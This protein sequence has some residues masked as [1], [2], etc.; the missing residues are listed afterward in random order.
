MLYRTPIHG[1]RSWGWRRRGNE[2]FNASTTTMDHRGAKETWRPFEGR[3]NR[4]RNSDRSS[5]DTTI[6]L[7][8][9]TSP[10][11]KTKES[12]PSRGF[13]RAEGERKMMRGFVVDLGQT[14]KRP[15]SDREIAAVGEVLSSV[16]LL[17]DRRKRKRL[18]R[19]VR[20]K[21]RAVEIGLKAKGKWHETAACSSELPSVFS[22]S[23]DAVF[24]R[25]G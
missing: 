8:A 24:R 1:Q 20:E 22:V 16:G 2:P 6:H 25:L 23:D 9:V 15:L 5:A 10:W 19:R 17:R 14:V 18:L 11:H 12:S 21:A 7:F 4:P 13:D 3:E